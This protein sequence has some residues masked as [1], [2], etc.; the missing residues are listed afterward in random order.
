MAQNGQL[1][2]PLFGLSLTRDNS[3]SLTFGT[4]RGVGVGPYVRLTTLKI[5]AIDGS[6][7]SNRTNIEWNEVVPF[8]PFAAESN[9]SSYL[10]WTIPLSRIAVGSAILTPQPTY[11]KNTNGFSLAL[12]DV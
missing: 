12:L 10:Q 4:F 3:G 8:A 5:G 1:D 6:V 2:Y 11:P 9:T 7:V